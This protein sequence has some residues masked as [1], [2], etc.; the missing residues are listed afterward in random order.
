MILALQF[1]HTLLNAR[2]QQPMQSDT[3]FADALEEVAEQHDAEL[4]K[5][6][7]SEWGKYVRKVMQRKLRSVTRVDMGHP[8]LR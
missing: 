6:P 2:E 4:E 3:E 5:L 7:L 1:R 8:R